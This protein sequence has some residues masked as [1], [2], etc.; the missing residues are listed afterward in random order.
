MGV[1]LRELAAAK[2]ITLEQLA[3]KVL[4]VDAFNALYQFLA[5]IRGRDGSLLTD[6]TGKVTSHLVG[7]FA[8][9]AA[10]RSQRI[11]PVFVFDGKSPGQKAGEQA[12][13]AEAKAAAQE[14]YEEARERGAEEE[15]RKYASRT[16]RLT[17][18]M[19][20][21][22]KRLLDLLGTPWVQAPS[23]GEA[24]AAHMA[25]KGDAWAAAS[26]DY[27]SLLHGAPRL[28]RNLAVSARR[29]GMPVSPE[30]IILDESLAGLG[31]DRDRLI[32]LAL[33]VGT[34][35]NPGGVKGIGPKKALALVRKHGTDHAALFAEARWTDHCPLDWR[36][37]MTLI[38]TIPVTDGYA[39][40]WRP[41]DRKALL[42]FLVDERGFGRERVEKSIGAIP[43]EGLGAF[44]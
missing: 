1:N 5:T 26:Q 20:M 18:E 43:Q 27:D 17:R 39:L 19:V 38:K 41:P 12:R 8:R 15:M 32:A 9:T 30:L 36:E 44:L 29:Q 2:P 42:A 4:A 10:L 13:R 31:L 23:E 33:L 3:G 21:D 14:R 22:A 11:R 7:L 6:A 16:S 24:Q 35:Y 40:R 34:D 37:L 28:V 25:R